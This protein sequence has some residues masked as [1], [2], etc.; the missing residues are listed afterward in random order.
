LSGPGKTSCA[1]VFH[2]L[3]HVILCVF[4]L[5]ESLSEAT[6]RLQL[7]TSPELAADISGVSI[8][9]ERYDLEPEWL[10]ESWSEQ[11]R[12]KR[13]SCQERREESGSQSPADGDRAHDRT[14]NPNVINQMLGSDGSLVI[15]CLEQGDLLNAEHI[16]AVTIPI[17]YI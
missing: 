8:S 5:S 2:R 16:I 11:S 12:S 17:F 9:H 7:V 13:R 6:W 14:P 15:R 4:R 3:L 10:V 1:F